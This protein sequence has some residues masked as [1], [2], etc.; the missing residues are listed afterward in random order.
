MINIIKYNKN[1]Y[2][3]S[4]GMIYTKTTKK[5]IF[6]N[7]IIYTIKNKTFKYP[8]IHINKIPLDYRIENLIQ[9]EPNKNIKKYR[10]VKK[11]IYYIWRF[12]KNSFTRIN[13]LGIYY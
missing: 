4:S 6:L 5:N 11:I 2:I 7:E 13:R 8:I 1:W 9:D 3:N 10:Y 12:Y